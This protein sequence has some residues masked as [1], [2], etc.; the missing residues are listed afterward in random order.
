[1][2]S[3]GVTPAIVAPIVA[4]VAGS[5]AS[6]GLASTLAPDGGGQKE[7]PGERK[8]ALGSFAS[9]MAAEE[10]QFKKP[11]DS[12]LLRPGGRPISFNN[13]QQRQPYSARQSLPQGNRPINFG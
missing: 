2:N 10:G 6:A 13:S 11:D 3:G 12:Y 9:R 5:M 7:L 4:A 8:K 1:M